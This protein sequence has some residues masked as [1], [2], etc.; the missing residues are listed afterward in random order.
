MERE[1]RYLEQVE[2]E[3]MGHRSTIVA[4]RRLRVSKTWYRSD[5]RVGHRSLISREHPRRARREMIGATLEISSYLKLHP[6]PATMAV[7]WRRG[8]I[9]MLRNVA[10]RRAIR[11]NSIAASSSLDKGVMLTSPDH[12]HILFQ[13]FGWS[14][15]SASNHVIVDICMAW[16][17]QVLLILAGTAT[18]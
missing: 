6:K 11:S 9:E 17:M 13:N 7:Q 2:W 4:V 3:T 12:E 8:E 18:A 5:R 10:P 1:D 14:G 16:Q 15:G